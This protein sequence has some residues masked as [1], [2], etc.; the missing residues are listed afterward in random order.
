[1]SLLSAEDRAKIDA[2]TAILVAARRG[3][4]D[5]TEV[6]E[7]VA[8]DWGGTD[9]R[10]YYGSYFVDDV[11]PGLRSV[12]GNGYRL[13]ARLIGGQF[14][15]IM[16]DSGTSDDSVALDLYDGDHEISDLFETYGEGVRVEIFLY[17][18]EV[19]LLLSQW[20][21]HLRDQDEADEEHFPTKAENGFMSVYLPLPRR[22]F[23][24]TC[25][26][27][28]AALLSTQEEIDE[29]EMCPY[30][31]HIEG[32]TFGNL[33]PAT[34][35]PYRTCPRN[36]RSAC[37][38]RIGDSLSYLAFDTIV[39]SYAVGSKGAI[40]TS[41]GNDNNL[42]R[43]LRVIFGDWIVRDLDLLEYV[44][45]TGNPSHPERGSIKLLHA[46]GEGYQ[47]GLSQPKANNTPIQPQH[48]STRPGDARQPST[49]FTADVNNFPHTAILNTVLQGDYRN[50]DPASI[51]MEI[52]TRGEK[53]VRVYASDDPADYTLE[54][55][56]DRAWALLH[57][58]RHKRWGLGGD[59]R[60]FAMEEDFIPLSSHFTGRITWTDEDG[61]TYTGPRSMFQ[62]ELIDRTAQQQINDICS[63]GRVTTP[64]NYEGKTRVFP[65]RKLSD[66]ELADALVF[67]DSEDFGEPNIIREDGTGKSTLTR[68]SV[69]DAELPN[70]IKGTFYDAAHDFTEHPF[71]IDNGRSID[72]QLRAGRAF[73][74]TGRRVVEKSY[75]LLGI[76]SYGMA[77]WIATLYRDLGE[78]DEGGIVNNQR[79]KFQT[80]FTRTIGL[81][82][83]KVI[84][85]LSHSL[86]NRRTG[87]QKFSFF[88]VRYVH[89]LSNLIAEIS[90]QAYPVPYYATVESPAPIGDG[91]GG[92]GGDTFIDNTHDNIG[93]LRGARPRDVLISALTHT[94][95]QIRLQLSPS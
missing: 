17:F 30:N 56:T 93:G 8:V 16:R 51:A 69:S 81:Y 3:E 25:Q 70:V 74:D 21:G 11:F 79:V 38:A 45:E 22:A 34:G 29:Y 31:R 65:Y 78:F 50:V 47:D 67:T 10:I 83:S 57:A 43:P 4:R 62:G 27:V 12:L 24:S 55:S 53:K 90:A 52:R 88:R 73:G 14:L 61:N 54:R 40:A 44:V 48:F 1:M 23:F 63:A 35:A 85:V 72:Q 68:S 13:E 18:P 28:F 26:A 59:V 94:D 15:D 46:I 19:G 82:K 41:R 77:R 37:T 33:D 20:H 39:Q 2:L 60:R 64:F 87:V 42:K 66:E 80:F 95:D 6:A 32:G 9:G 91:D 92:G 76:T 75:G 7:L 84:C 49:G 71:T 58:L 89:R 5:Q 86:V 36:S